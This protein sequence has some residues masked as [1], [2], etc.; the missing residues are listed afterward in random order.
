MFDG[1]EMKTSLLVVGDEEAIGLGPK[2]AR[3]YI[4]E[5]IEIKTRNLESREPEST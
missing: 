4:E 3:L 2:N 1:K 5:M